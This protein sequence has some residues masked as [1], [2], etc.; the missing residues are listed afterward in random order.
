M[1]KRRIPSFETERLVIRPLSKGDL[2][3][4]TAILGDPD[5]MRF[6]V[7]GVCDR[8]ATRRFLGWSRDCHAIRG[9]GPMALIDR[10]SNEFVGFCGL[11]PEEV[12][13]VEEVGIGYRLARRF[14][15]R[16]LAPEAARTVMAHGFD[17]LRLETVVAVI[18]PANLASIR[19]AEKI[20]F[21]AF[22][23]SRFHGREVRLYRLCR[24][25]WREMANPVG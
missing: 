20:G 18:E 6:S 25:Q 2:S 15:H 5:V 10:E 13:G 1:I 9:F 3:D 8:R 14:W 11:V 22:V 16:G 17:V 7:R 4:L 21:R 23:T 24:T 12:E 19:V